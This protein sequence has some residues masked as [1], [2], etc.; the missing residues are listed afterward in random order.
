MSAMG[1]KRP[2][3]DTLSNVCFWGQNG[4]WQWEGKTKLVVQAIF[5]GAVILYP[6]AK[7]DWVH[8]LLGVLLWVTAA[9]T[10]WSAVSYVRRAA[11]VLREASD[12]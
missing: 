2:F 6:G 5:C 1:H 10:V 7:W 12:V 9:V 8:D 11:E 3:S 4:H